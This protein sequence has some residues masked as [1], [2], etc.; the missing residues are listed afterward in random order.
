[1][2][3]TVDE[4]APEA[5]VDEFVADPD[6]S[7]PELSDAKAGAVETAMTEPEAATATVPTD[8]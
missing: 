4:P 1:V 3:A 2:V 5:A 6:D 7:K 8:D